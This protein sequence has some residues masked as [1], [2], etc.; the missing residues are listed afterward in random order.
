MSYTNF[1]FWVKT[2]LSASGS[3]YIS[4]ILQSWT[5]VAVLGDVSN[6]N[7]WHKRVIVSS[8]PIHDRHF[9]HSVWN[10]AKYSIVDTVISLMMIWLVSRLDRGYKNG[11][12]TVNDQNKNR[13]QNRNR[14]MIRFIQ[15][16]IPMHRVISERKQNPIKNLS[17]N[18]I[19]CHWTPH[20]ME[21]DRI[22]IHLN[23]LRKSEKR[24]ESLRFERNPVLINHQITVK[25]VF[26]DQTVNYGH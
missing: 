6:V 19:Q 12:Q 7:P 26:W 16:L 23:L 8:Y 13:N 11:F 4:S 24:D 20:Q 3:S 17:R 21:M 1:Q 15:T 10:L 5:S 14:T 9:K 22:Q 2:L 25:F 18:L